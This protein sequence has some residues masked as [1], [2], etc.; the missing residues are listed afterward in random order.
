MPGYRYPTLAVWPEP[1][2]EVNRW[3][4]HEFKLLPDGTT[5]WYKG[6]IECEDGHC[7]ADV[8]DSLHEA[9]LVAE[10]RNSLL[11]KQISTLA[12]EKEALRSIELKTI[13]SIQCKSRLAN[14]EEL[15]LTEAMRRAESTERVNIKDLELPEESEFLRDQ[16]FE[17]LNRMPYLKVVMLK[18]TPYAKILYKES[19][20]KWSKPYTVTKRAAQ[21]AARATI[22]NGFGF[23]SRAHW[24]KTKARI[25]EILLPRANQLLQ[26]A[27]VQRILAD[28]RTRGQK[29]IVCNGYIFWYEEDG[30]IGWQIKQTTESSG[31]QGVTV[32]CEG[33]ILSKNHGRL[34]VLPYIKENGE[35]IQGH[36]KNA[37]GDGRAKPRHP[38][39]YLELPFETLK[40]DLMVGLFGELSYE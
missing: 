36:T 26:L 8:Y 16:L 33:T 2:Y 14:E 39:Q 34:V 12:Y 10:Q 18:G 17:T 5:K 40:D 22:A 3:H 4:I 38:E 30:N 23:S 19:K 15:M 9:I 32:W 11:F 25:R 35:H 37:P 20:T 27:S 13:K 7:K 21:Y 24:G 31:L 6:W 28:A 1:W 29:V